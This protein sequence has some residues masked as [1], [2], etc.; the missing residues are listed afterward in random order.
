[1]NQSSDDEF[2]NSSTENTA[3]A[4]QQQGPGFA[5]PPQSMPDNYPPRQPGRGPQNFPPGPQN[6]SPQ[7]L[8]GQPGGVP[9]NNPQ[10]NPPDRPERSQV[11]WSPQEQR[12]LNQ[13]GD[14]PRSFAARELS[15]LS[16]PN[17]QQL[18]SYPPPS[19]PISRPG[20]SQ[21]D[22]SAQDLYATEHATFAAD[23]TQEGS[24]VP[25]WQT[26]N[27]PVPVAPNLAPWEQQKP[28]VPPPNLAPWEQQ[29]PPVPPPNLAPWEQ[30]QQSPRP[31]AGTPANWSGPGP[32]QPPPPVRPRRF[33]RTVL[34]MLLVLGVLV[35]IGG[36]G[37]IFALRSRGGPSPTGTSTTQGTSTISGVTPVPSAPGSTPTPDGVHGIGTPV[38]AGTDWIATITSIRE[39]ISSL[40]A[41]NPNNTYLEVNLSLKNTSGQALTLVSFLE[42]T[43]DGPNG[44]HLHETGGDTNIHRPPDG[45][46]NANS[47]LVAEVAYEVPKNQ[48]AFTLV[49]AYGL[50]H[51]NNASV[52]WQLTA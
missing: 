17:Q 31:Q 14:T 16:S 28:P 32:T 15:D 52:S 46:V 24:V 44:L 9:Q 2:Y 25:P 30:Q 37:G 20:F 45:T 43:L 42:F 18:A 29:K 10:Q 27:A 19:G 35:V 11:F 21:A 49:F 36:I 8:P 48:H 12:P 33:S 23:Y 50:S 40:I 39:T 22:N 47:T 4:P 41:P 13:P 26:F 7:S 6:Y 51:N 34:I 1:M 5:R 3:S 38:Q